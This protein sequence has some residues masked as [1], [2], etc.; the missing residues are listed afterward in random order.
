LLTRLSS[1]SE[2]ALYLLFVDES[3]THGGSHSFILGGIAVHEQ[4]AYPLG[5]QL[6]RVVASAVPEHVATEDFELHGAEMRNAKSPASRGERPASLWASVPRLRRLDALLAGYRALTGFAPTD[7][8][9]PVALFGVVIDR[10]FRSGLPPIHRERFAYEVLL[11]KFDVILKRT[12]RNVDST[13]GLVI[14][15]RRIV[16][17]RDIQEWTRQW[18]RAAGTLPQLR[19]LADVPLFADSRASRL[20]QAAD[21]VS[22]ALYRHYDPSRKGVDYVEAL[23]PRFD[24]VDDVMH[25]CVHYTPSFGSQSCHCLPCVSRAGAGRSDRI[26]L[27][28]SLGSI[29]CLGHEWDADPAA[30]VRDQRGGC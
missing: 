1:F 29:D 9:F 22:Y 8:S 24:S 23:W 27:L 18:Q 28:D 15:D 21:L 5:V 20:L 16:A 14:H 25:G 7:P 17:E 19:N 3:G 12:R 13:R 6:D 11:T 30:W 2:V 4:D 10:R 26:R